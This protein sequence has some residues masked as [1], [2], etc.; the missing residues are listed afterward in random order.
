VRTIAG[1]RVSAKG[2]EAHLDFNGVE[3]IVD[4]FGCRPSLLRDPRRVAA[5]F[6][7][8]VGEMGLKPIGELTWH[9]FPGPAGI[10]GFLLL[11]ESHLACHTFPE[12][13][14]LT[15]NLFCC[16]ERRR[17]PEAAWVE[18]IFGARE[19]TV[20]RISRPLAAP[21]PQPPAPSRAPA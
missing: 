10:T 14:A 21:R 20:R 19:I 5:L 18:E 11:T 6:A 8:V 17:E 13:G 15:L 7:R 3:W 9:Q 4:A 1:A 16:R 2:D 12:L